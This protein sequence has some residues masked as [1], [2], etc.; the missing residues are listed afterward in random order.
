[1]SD[2]SRLLAGATQ[3]V[4]D[5][6]VAELLGDAAL[7]AERDD[8]QRRAINRALNQH[9]PLPGTIEGLDQEALV[10]AVADIND[11][12]R[13]AVALSCLPRA[14]KVSSTIDGRFNRA[15]RGVLT[16]EDKAHVD[17]FKGDPNLPQSGLQ[18]GQWH[19]EEALLFGGLQGLLMGLE[20]GDAIAARFSLR[21]PSTVFDAEPSVMLKATPIVRQLCRKILQLDPLS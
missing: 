10:L 6:R 11:V 17:G 19:S 15:I 21:F 14:G 12:K 9:H 4:D 20:F 8:L 13:C 18:A 2:F 7:L 1:M 5:S 16:P 3:L